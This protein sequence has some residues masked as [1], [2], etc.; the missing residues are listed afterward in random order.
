M[1]NIIITT[2]TVPQRMPKK[3][4]KRNKV[5]RKKALWASYS[6]PKGRCYPLGSYRI[7]LGEYPK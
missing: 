6:H 1:I 5:R 7:L 2:Q 4:K 3:E